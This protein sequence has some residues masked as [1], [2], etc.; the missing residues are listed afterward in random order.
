[1]TNRSGNQESGSLCQEFPNP[2]D[3][4]GLFADENEDAAGQRDKVE[5]EDGWPEIQAES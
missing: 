1:M 5:Q 2:K 4:I 3:C